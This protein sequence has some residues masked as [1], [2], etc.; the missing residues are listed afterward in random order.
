MGRLSL[1]VQAPRESGPESRE[2][3]SPPRN[4][5]L[6]PHPCSLQQHQALHPYSE[7][8]ADKA[9][10]LGSQGVR[11]LSSVRLDGELW[12]SG[13]HAGSLGLPAAV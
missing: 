13:I 3:C 8:S 10:F 2:L 5:P 4:C 12:V 6:P 7:M 9:P 11:T 1:R